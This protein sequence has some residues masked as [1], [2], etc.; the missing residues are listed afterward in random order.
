MAQSSC[1]GICGEGILLQHS[2][3]SRSSAQ[4][5]SSHSSPLRILHAP[6]LRPQ[7]SRCGGRRCCRRIRGDDSSVGNFDSS[8]ARRRGEPWHACG[9][10]DNVLLARIAASMVCTSGSA[11]STWRRPL[12]PWQPPGTCRSCGGRLASRGHAS[13]GSSS[14]SSLGL[15]AQH[16]SQVPEDVRACGFHVPA[17]LFTFSAAYDAS[18]G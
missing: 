7:Q 6:L 2:L 15:V 12:P 3:S 18:L 14:D 11:S 17:V 8:S 5:S 1:T 10:V 9:D 16:R 13:A 4:V